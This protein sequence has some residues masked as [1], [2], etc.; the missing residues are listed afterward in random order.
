M[1]LAEG[2]F[3]GEGLAAL[4]VGLG[5]QWGDG[6][7]A[8]VE[9]LGDGLRGGRATLLV[10]GGWLRPAAPAGLLVVGDAIC[11]RCCLGGGARRQGHR[12]ASDGGDLVALTAEVLVAGSLG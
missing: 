8:L 3:E 10:T 12:A 5:I 6:L 1:M 2:F 4:V 11:E 9:G 7:T